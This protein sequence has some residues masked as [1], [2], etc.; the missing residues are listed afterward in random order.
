MK[1]YIIIPLLFI[2]LFNCKIVKKDW[3]KENYVEKTEFESLENVVNSSNETATLS[4]DFLTLEKFNEF[5]NALSQK[6]SESSSEATTV[7]GTI[8]AE[9]GK[10]KTATIGNTTITSNGA[11]ISFE[12]QN[13]KE[14]S[15]SIELLQSELEQYKTFSENR[16]NTLEQAFNSEKQSRIALE[17]ELKSIKDTFTKNSDKKGFTFGTTVL[18]LGILLL[19]IALVVGYFYVKKKLG[20]FI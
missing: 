7:T 3:L 19:I 14:A 17:N 6:S 2:S 9:E 10:E 16:Y 12:I 15:K 18:I 13:L 20:W 1:K 5:V 11:N 4:E 8:E